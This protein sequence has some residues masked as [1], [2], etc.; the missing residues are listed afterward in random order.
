MITV[1][2]LHKSFGEGDKK[3]VVL[4]DFS[5]HFETG[6]TTSIIGGSGSGKSTV[7]KHLIGVYKPDQGEIIIDGEDITKLNHEGLSRV[8]KKFGIMFQ[9]GALFNS[10]TVEDNVALPLRE[11]TQLNESTIQIMVKM[12]LEMV[13]LR[14]A[15]HLKP[16]QLSGG[17]IK[18]IA[19]ARA[20][21]LDPK[22]VFY[23]EPS[24]GLDPISIGVIDKL[25]MDLSKK[26]RITSV[27][28]THEIPSAMRISDKIIMLYKGKIIASGTPEDIRQSEDPRVQQFINGSPDGPIPFSKSQKDYGAELKEMEF[29]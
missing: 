22:I 12:K 23:D 13:G 8:R 26:M 9:S 17:M 10:L 2:H 28:I 20:I 1:N 16:A 6:K 5:A 27:V 11:H 29:T 21:A 15:D 24:A 25:I 7:L 4:D 18:R 14:G 3:L 19:L